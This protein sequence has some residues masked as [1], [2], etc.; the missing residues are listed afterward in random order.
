MHAFHLDRT[1]AMARS[2]TTRLLDAL[3]SLT[4][5]IAGFGRTRRE[6][7]RQHA[8]FGSLSDKTLSDIGLE[9]GKLR[10]AEYGILPAKQVLPKAS[11]R[12]TACKRED[13]R[14]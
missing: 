2:V 11:T 1:P 12:Q 7:H 9:R 8:H 6:R 13:S 10:A 14:P 3:T 5:R 4:R